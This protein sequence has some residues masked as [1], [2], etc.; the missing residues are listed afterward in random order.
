MSRSG[1]ETWW[2]SHRSL[3]TP[4]SERH[5]CYSARRA[6]TCWSS[7]TSMLHRWLANSLGL[8]CKRQSLFNS[9][10]MFDWIFACL[11]LGL[12]CRLIPL[13]SRLSTLSLY[14]WQICCL[15]HLYRAEC[16]LG[17]PYPLY[18]FY[19]DGRSA[20][21]STGHSDDLDYGIREG[22]KERQIWQEDYVD[23]KPEIPR[24][25]EHPHRPD[26]Q[27]PDQVWK[28]QVWDSNHHPC[29]PEGYLWW[30]V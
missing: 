13:S 21:E 15:C 28:D 2:S 29:T 8:P 6:S 27:R 18:Q 4:S 12:V 17:Y 22:S 11:A 24:T 30:F 10:Y 26:H 25:A 14:L 5:T 23:H 1:W 3:Y 19:T 9:M 16:W 20:G 7:L